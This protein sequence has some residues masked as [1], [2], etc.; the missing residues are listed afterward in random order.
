PQKRQITRLDAYVDRR[1]VL[2]QFSE[3]K[4]VVRS[5]RIDERIRPEIKPTRKRLANG[6]GSHGCEIHDVGYCAYALR[7][8]RR[9]PALATCDD[10]L[11]MCAEP[12]CVTCHPLTQ[13][14]AQR[15]R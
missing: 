5:G 1:G 6:R 7:R 10:A 4:I 2:A 15:R 11:P 8:K 13:H 14:L 12:F 9:A 3:I